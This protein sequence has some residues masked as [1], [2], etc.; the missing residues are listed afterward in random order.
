MTEVQ[1]G[2][3][4]MEL[5]AR[6]LGGPTEGVDMRA[7]FADD[8]QWAELRD[9]WGQGFTK[10]CVFAWVALGQRNERFG[11]EGLR[12]GWLDWFEPW[13][14]Y[15]SHVEEMRPIGDDKVLA[16]ATQVGVLREGTPVEMHAAALVTIRDG[17]ISAVDFYA[18]REEAIAA[19]EGEG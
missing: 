2:A 16:I 8:D 6:A 19:V 10:D 5:V 1:Q 15:R 12:E 13:A 18:T 9:A 11:P 7:V 4:N 17:L 14:E 3:A